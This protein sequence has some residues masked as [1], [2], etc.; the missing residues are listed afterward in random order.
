MEIIRKIS[1]EP[2]SFVEYFKKIWSYRSLIWVFAKRDLKVK[3]AQTVIGM[4]WSILQPLTALIIYSFFFGFI[5]NWKADNLP[6][7]VYVLS[8]L[9]GWNFFSYI[10]YQGSSSIQDAGNTIKKI[11]FPKS[12]LPFSKMVIALV[13]LVL[14]LLLLIPLLIYYKISIS[15]NIIFFPLAILF[16]AICGLLPVFWIATFAYKKRDLFHLLPYL[17]TFGIWFTPVFFSTNILPERLSFLMSFNPMANVIE[18][19]RWI[20]FS[21]GEF[22]WVWII[23]FFIVTALCI[24]GM[25]FYNQKESEFSDYV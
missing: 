20:L 1:S 24:I 23:N 14:S 21:F 12:I 4:G 17:V 6:F 13:E 2:D 16:N 15:W 3:Y 7:P 25:Y 8:G 18:F 19:W 10:V 9:I 11:Y 5:L 22:E